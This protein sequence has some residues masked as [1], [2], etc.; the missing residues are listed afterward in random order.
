MHSVLQSTCAIQELRH[1]LA[2]L[3]NKVIQS[4]VA[5]G[6]KNAD[7]FHGSE[8]SKLSFDVTHEPVPYDATTSQTRLPSQHLKTQDSTQHRLSYLEGIAE[9]ISEMFKFLTEEKRRNDLLFTGVIAMRQ[10]QCDNDFEKK[11]L[12]E[13]NNQLQMRVTELER[14]VISG[15]FKAKPNIIRKK[16]KRAQVSVD[17]EEVT[18]Q[19]RQTPTQRE[20]NAETRNHQPNAR[21]KARKY[22]KT[23]SKAPRPPNNRNNSAQKKILIVGDSQLK[24]INENKLSNNSKSVK[25]TAVGGMR[26]ENLMSHVEHDKWDNIIVHVGTNNLKEGNSMKITD[27]LD[28]CLT[29]IQARNPDCQVAYSGIFKRKDNPE[30]N[31]C[32]QEVNDKIKER[33]MQRGIDFI[34]NSNILFNNLYRDG[35]HLSTE[36]G[37]PKYCKNLSNYLRYSMCS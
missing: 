34:D 20:K 3:K 7:E 14:I 9:S 24:R 5:E 32:G 35:L 33:L 30:F 11:S 37:V 26:I 10:C 12:Q 16:D 28:E 27:K 8:Q 4:S 13:E 22:G 15:D 1:E 36:G 19:F 2:I 21:L 18:E 6:N 29:Y 25:V 31:K 17:D 23:T